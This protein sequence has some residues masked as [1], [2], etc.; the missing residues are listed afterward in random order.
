MAKRNNVVKFT[1]R[2]TVNIG[3]IIFA[4]I[5]IYLVISIIMFSFSKKTMI[6]EVNAG[7]LAFNTTYTGFVLRNERVYQ[8]EY[9]GRINYFLNSGERASIDTT[10]YSV[11]EVGRV[12]DKI[13]ESMILELDSNEINLIKDMITNYSSSYSSSDFSDI[14]KQSQSISNKIHE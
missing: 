8:S 7:S 14:Y 9:S 4:V 5:F 11:D 2:P 3:L 6:Y 1:R 12:A 10:I 13:E